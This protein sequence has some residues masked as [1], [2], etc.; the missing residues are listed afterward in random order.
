MGCSCSTQSV[1]DTIN[2]LYDDF[3]IT[4]ISTI[5]YI[6][7]FTEY[8]N[9]NSDLIFD[10]IEGIFF[11]STRYQ[12]SKFL[13]TFYSSSSSIALTRKDILLSII[14]LTHGNEDDFYKVFLKID[15]ITSEIENKV[16]SQQRGVSYIQYSK[17]LELLEVY[18]EMISIYSLNRIGETSNEEDDRHENI[19]KKFQIEKREELISSFILSKGEKKIDLKE[20]IYRKKEYLNSKKLR[21]MLYD[22]DFYERNE[23]AGRSTVGE[24]PRSS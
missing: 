8:F 15:E 20:F 13:T 10:K 23:T 14:F 2:E 4:K 21:E 16:T 19:R 7:I 12:L 11:H 18:I 3:Q 22:P 17:L 6:N 5:D 9:M 24:T 1:E